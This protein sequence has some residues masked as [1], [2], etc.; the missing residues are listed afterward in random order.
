MIGDV[1]EGGEVAE[2][3]DLR[4]CLLFGLGFVLILG[5]VLVALVLPVLA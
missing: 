5:F 3:E 2:D 1:E 4:R